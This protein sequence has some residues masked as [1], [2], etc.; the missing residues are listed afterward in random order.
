MLLANSWLNAVGVVLLTHS[1]VMSAYLAH[2]FM[3][4]TIFR[5]FKWNEIG[6]SVMLW[7]NGGCY[8]RFRDLAQDHI[9]H[10]VNR[11]DYSG[12]DL[13]KFFARLP[14]S[15]RHAILALEWL[16]FPIISYL[17]GWRAIAAPF[18]LP[19]RRD[20]R[21]RVAL[22]LGVRAVLFA[23]LSLISL[24]ALL[25]YWLSY[26]GMILVL[27]LLDAFQHTYEV[28]PMGSLLPKRDR[29]YEHANTFTTLISERYWW[30]NLLLLN[31]GYHT[32]IMN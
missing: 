19:R 17:L 11:V 5:S 26:T 31:F 2:E 16:Y 24:K 3:H 6:G 9:G 27:R 21:G 8:A 32:P 30:L 29:I 12:F 1:L 18:F 28:F 23:V 25:L 13:L 4:G 15:V 7:L 22:I 20:E 10:H 14:T